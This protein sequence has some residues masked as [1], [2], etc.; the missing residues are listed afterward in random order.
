MTLTQ[1]AAQSLRS[2]SA[3]LITAGAGMGVDSGLP[4]FR[5]TEGFWNAYPPYRHLGL[6]FSELASPRWFRDEPELAWGFYG[7]RLN[8][9]RSTKPHAGFDILLKWSGLMAAG[10]HIFTSN[11]DGQFQIAGFPERQITEV[12]GSI[13]HLQCTESCLNIWPADGTN[14]TVD[15]ETFRAVGALPQC[16]Q[17]GAMARPNILMFGDDGWLPSRTAR[18]DAVLD[19]WLSTLGS[20]KLVIIECGAGSTIPTVRRF[21]E[22][23]AAQ[24]DGVLIRIN[25]R[26]SDVPDNQ[27]GLAMPAATAMA[28]IDAHI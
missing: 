28:A 24:F 5:G 13:H 16:P 20:Q 15:P 12:H 23:A 21:S 7:H 17:C 19:A 8:L 4:D 2:A 9:Y 27:V 26:E 18:Q 10:A 11:V 25:L 6:S 22:R 1:L 3:L 14:V